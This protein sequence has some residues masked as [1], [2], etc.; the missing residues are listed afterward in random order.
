MIYQCL[1]KKINGYKK[2]MFVFILFC[3]EYRLIIVD[4]SLA[5]G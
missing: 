4:D 5:K 3:G 2:C 1:H